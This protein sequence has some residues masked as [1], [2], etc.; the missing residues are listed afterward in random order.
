MM[1]SYKMIPSRTSHSATTKVIVTT[2]DTL[3]SFL[4]IHIE[5]A[6]SSL[7]L[8]QPGLITKIIAESELQEASPK[9]TPMVSTYD[10]QLQDDSPICDHAVYRRLLGMI[11]FL[12]RTRP[13]I[14]YAVTRLATRTSIAT[15][16]DMSALLRVIRYLKGASHLELVFSR[17]PP[18]PILFG[19]A[20]AS[21]INHPDGRSHSGTC[22]GFGPHSGMFHYRSIKQK[23][24]AL[25]SAKTEVSAATELTKDVVH[26]QDLFNELGLPNLYPL[27]YLS[28][29]KALSPSP[30]SSL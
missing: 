26:F 8:S 10:E 9:S 11:L 6:N 12:L 3:E 19:Y 29:T 14:S 23:T 1:N 22:V 15:E 20:D 27:P 25:S 24:T 30:P 7:Y 17:G 21:Y 18:H 16:K 13:D 5:A 28:T 4:G 2:S